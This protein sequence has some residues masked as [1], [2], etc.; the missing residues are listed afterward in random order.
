MCK[1]RCKVTCCYGPNVCVPTNS[2]VETLT[3]KLMVMGGRAFRKKLGCE[4]GA[5]VNGFSAPVKRDTRTGFLA[6]CHM[7]IPGEDSCLQTR[8]RALTRHC[9]CWHLDLELP[10]LQTCEQ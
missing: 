4:G 8:K 9:I 6:L 1:L 7:R 3:P 10:S 2:Y 5:H